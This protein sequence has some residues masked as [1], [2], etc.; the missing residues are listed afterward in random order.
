MEPNH[1]LRSCRNALQSTNIIRTPRSQ[2]RAFSEPPNRSPDSFSL[3][4][5][6]TGMRGGI[7]PCPRFPTSPP[8]GLMRRSRR[9]SA[10]SP[11]RQWD[12]SIFGAPS[13]PAGKTASRSRWCRPQKLKP[14]SAGAPALPDVAKRKGRL[15]AADR[16]IVGER[17]CAR[18]C[19]A[20]FRARVCR[21]PCRPVDA[22]N[23]W[24]AATDAPL[25]GQPGALGWRHSSRYRVTSR[26]FCMV[27]SSSNSSR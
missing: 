10:Q 15:D 11:A 18:C 1:N 27:R 5:L 8:A 14:F 17:R 13:P 25:R 19:D 26:A 21:R 22:C 2:F 9:A 24:H 16:E 3:M 12:S 20:A 23:R 6:S 7:S 4:H